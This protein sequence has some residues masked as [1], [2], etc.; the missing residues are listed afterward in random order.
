M[1]K[2]RAYAKAVIRQKEIKLKS[3][4]QLIWLLLA[5]HANEQTNL[6]YFTTSRLCDMT[7]CTRNTVRSGI[8][9][10]E[11]H[12]LI[13]TLY[14]PGKSP[15]YTVHIPDGFSAG[16]DTAVSTVSR[17]YVPTQAELAA[18]AIET[19]LRLTGITA[20]EMAMVVF[21]GIEGMSPD[22]A[23][24]RAI[25]MLNE[26]DLSPA[27]TI[28][29]QLGIARNS[30]VARSAQEK[31]NILDRQRLAQEELRQSALKEQ[32]VKWEAPRPGESMDAW[33]KRVTAG[34][35]GS[36]K[37]LLEYKAAEY[38]ALGR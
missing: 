36:D 31:A 20:E 34:W 29:E 14:N 1:W 18:S 5:D 26:S 32:L 3:S 9:K 21:T 30:P 8:K 10:L 23:K 4:E 27:R 15:V 38:Q 35:Q 28:I 7:Q 6:T 16:S 17:A 25:T 24:L 2:H 13:S 22:E 11:K 37:E 33:T 19:A 12:H